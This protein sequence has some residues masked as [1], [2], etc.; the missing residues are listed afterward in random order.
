MNRRHVALFL[1]GYAS[2]VLVAPLGYLM[3]A[4]LPLPDL[5]L[6][7]VLYL[8]VAVKGSPS[9]GL[10]CAVGLGYL[11][12]LFSGAPRGLYSLT[13][14]ICYFVVRGLS[15]RLYLRGKLSQMLVSGIVSLATSTL[16]VGL[17]VALNPH[18]TWAMLSPAPKTALA[19]A[20]VSP[21][22]LWLLWTLDRKMAPEVSF[23]GVFR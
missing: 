22:V 11:A 15:A 17:E 18:A 8:A 9:A 5:V 10:A 16:L 13:L 7:V 2:L 4:V 3:P 20:L 19:T 21:V 12:D 14:G 1:A 6:L 23:E